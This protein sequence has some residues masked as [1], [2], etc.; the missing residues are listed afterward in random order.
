MA[1]VQGQR[2]E[3]WEDKLR[4]RRRAEENVMGNGVKYYFE[5]VICEWPRQ[6]FNEDLTMT[7]K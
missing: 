4:D 7:I 5:Y 2:N 1:Y 3:L 6:P